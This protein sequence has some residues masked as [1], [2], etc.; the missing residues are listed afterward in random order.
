MQ[1]KTPLNTYEFIFTI[2]GDKRSQKDKHLVLRKVSLSVPQGP[3]RSV[4]SPPHSGLKELEFGL[5][6][7]A[8]VF[9]CTFTWRS[10]GVLEEED[11]GQELEDPL[12]L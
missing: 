6:R 10:A 1:E 7:D 8:T 9:T 3:L 5:Q 11:Q 4:E 12:H 2:R